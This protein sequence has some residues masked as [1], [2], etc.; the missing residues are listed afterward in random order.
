MEE[1]GQEE[2]QERGETRSVAVSQSI[3]RT[4][5]RSICV[6]RRLKGERGPGCECAGCL[7]ECAANNNNNK[8]VYSTRLSNNKD[9]LSAVVK[10]N[11]FINGTPITTSRRHHNHVRH[12]VVGP[13]D[14]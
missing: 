5:D 1:E 8:D 3:D 12:S 4:I 14:L 13:L 10:D 11:S 9:G 2:E 7:C 6:P